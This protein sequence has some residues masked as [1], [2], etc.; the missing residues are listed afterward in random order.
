MLSICLHINSPSVISNKFLTASS[1]HKPLNKPKKTK[2]LSFHFLTR[3]FFI[4]I[5]IDLSTSAHDSLWWHYIAMLTTMHILLSPPAK[6][7]LWHRGRGKNRRRSNEAASVVEAIV[8]WCRGLPLVWRLLMGWVNPALLVAVTHTSDEAV[9]CHTT[10]VFQSFLMRICLSPASH[11][12]SG[13]LLKAN[14]SFLILMEELNTFSFT[15]KFFSLHH[16]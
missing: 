9:Q 16:E 14:N 7:R 8:G 3:Y 5:H 1:S 4:R 12:S 2:L 11:P 6:A 10:C 15:I 13:P